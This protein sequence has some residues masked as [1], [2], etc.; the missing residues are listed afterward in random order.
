MNF[1]TALAIMF[2]GYID[3]SSS[4]VL[5]KCRCN[6]SPVLKS[7]HCTGSWLI[8][9]YFHHIFVVPVFWDYFNN[10]SAFL[11]HII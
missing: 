2:L 6:H 7:R 1:L 10:Q 9:D 4:I 8:A 11:I 5:K 3:D